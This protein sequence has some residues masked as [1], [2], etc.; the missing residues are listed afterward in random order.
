ML[1]WALKEPK[2]SCRTSLQ[3]TPKRAAKAVK[4]LL[5]VVSLQTY[6]SSFW[7]DSFLQLFLVMFLISSRFRNEPKTYAEFTE[8][9][10]EH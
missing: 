6:V 8:S 9:D 2:F 10:G 1:H 7:K 3:K 4:D 5:D